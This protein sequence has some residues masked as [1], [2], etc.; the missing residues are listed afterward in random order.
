MAEENKASSDTLDGTLLC[1]MCCRNFWTDILK[2]SLVSYFFWVGLI[3]FLGS[4][5]LLAGYTYSAPRVH[6]EIAC[7]MTSSVYVFVGLW[8]FQSL[9]F[10]FTCWAYS[11]VVIS[12]E[13]DPE[14]SLFEQLGTSQLLIGFFVKTVPTW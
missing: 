2:L 3:Y 7:P 1:L 13:E 12:G 5:I 11:T 4:V 14:N 8:L 9:I 10:F 6:S